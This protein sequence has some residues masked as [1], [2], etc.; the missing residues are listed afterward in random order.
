[1]Y[2]FHP[3]CGRDVVVHEVIEKAGG[4]A[5]RCSLD[6]SEVERRLEIPAWMFD[7]AACAGDAHFSANPFVS[8]E[9]LDALSALLNQVLKLDT[10]SSNVRVRGAGGISHDLNRGEDHGTED[11]GTGDLQSVQAAPRR[12]AVGFARK[13]SSDR[14]TQM[15]RR[16]KGSAGSVDRSDGA[17]DPG[18]RADKHG[19][20]NGRSRP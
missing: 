15:V 2:R 4:G 16:A 20:D 12:T 17:A 8:L 10:T 13:R 5:F 11:D 14:Y 1:L 6:G 19:A 18:A 3:W 9:T 7:R